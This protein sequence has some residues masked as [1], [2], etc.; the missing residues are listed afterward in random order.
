MIRF[1]I[2]T[3]EK[4]ISFSNIDEVAIVMDSAGIEELCRSLE[5]LKTVEGTNHLHLSIFGCCDIDLDEHAPTT[6]NC[7]LIPQVR[8]VKI[9]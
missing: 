3:T 7:T 6:P 9:S 5:R 8:I 2:F 1:E 4:A